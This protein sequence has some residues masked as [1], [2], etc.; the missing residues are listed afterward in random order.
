MQLSDGGVIGLHRAG[1]GALNYPDGRDA[2]RRGPSVSL[3]GLH[4]YVSLL[5]ERRESCCRFP[6]YMRN[7]GNSCD[8]KGRKKRMS[9]PVG[10][11][12]LFLSIRICLATQASAAHWSLAKHAHSVQTERRDWYSFVVAALQ[13]EEPNLAT[14]RSS[15][16]FDMYNFAPRA[17]LNCRGHRSTFP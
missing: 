5:S 11:S 13:G 2:A 17:L 6:K 10:C 14:T 8:Y 15:R 12:D 7:S 4:R 3:S 1:A 9:G 16:V